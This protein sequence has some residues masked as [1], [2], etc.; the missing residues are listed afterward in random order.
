MCK[1][2]AWAVT[3]VT[4]IVD[5]CTLPSLDASHVSAPGRVRGKIGRRRWL[6][7][8]RRTSS[9]LEPLVSA[10]AGCGTARHEH[11]SNPQVHASAG[12]SLAQRA[13][14]IA[15]CT[16]GANARDAR[17]SPGR[18]VRAEGR[19]RQARAWRRGDRLL[20]LRS[21]HHRPPAGPGR[22]G[23]V[24]AASQRRADPHRSR[25]FGRLGVWVSTAHVT[26]GHLPQARRS[27]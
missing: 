22:S 9:R 7:R 13:Q 27:W 8:N 10:G 4:L 6:W 12:S 15:V 5:D 21:T 25:A 24:W 17:P 16:A 14:S 26:A 11:A 19:G 23:L 2:L 1:A 20:H 18:V 3:R